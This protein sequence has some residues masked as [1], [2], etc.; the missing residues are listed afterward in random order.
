MAEPAHLVFRAWV[1]PYFAAAAIVL[2]LAALVLVRGRGPVRYP[3]FGFLLALGAP[4]LGWGALRGAGDGRTA[5]WAIRGALAVAMFSGPT[6]MTVAAAMTNRPLARL[7]RLAW[8]G[9]AATA[10]A[11]LFS[12]LMVSGARPFAYGWM[13]NAG[14]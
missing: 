12:P 5:L 8:V 14:P 3:F 2:G 11:V 4:M 6:A 9:A 10:A 7:A 1:V 13:A